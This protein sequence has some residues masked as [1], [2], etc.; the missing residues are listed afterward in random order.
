M[1]PITSEDLTS[2]KLGSTGCLT[3]VEKKHIEKKRC[4]PSIMG[5]EVVEGRA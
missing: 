4:T 1:N 2:K 5:E 3:G